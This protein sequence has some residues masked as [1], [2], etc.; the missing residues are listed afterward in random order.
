MVRDHMHLLRLTKQR[1]VDQVVGGRGTG[2]TSLLRLLLETSDVSPTA[3]E[4]QRVSLE[5]FLKGSLKHSRHINTACV[6][7]H[8]SRYDRVLLTVIDTPGLDFGDGMEL[9]IERQVSEIIKYLD[10]QYADTMN[11]V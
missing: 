6:E 5:H 7:I 10:T 9:R 4:E 1:H 3:T 2:K 11:E 8:E